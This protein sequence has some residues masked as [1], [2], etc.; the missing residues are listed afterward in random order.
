[1]VRSQIL[2]IILII[3]MVKRLSIDHGYQVLGEHYETDHKSERISG[4]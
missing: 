3:K 1:M 2:A 4:W